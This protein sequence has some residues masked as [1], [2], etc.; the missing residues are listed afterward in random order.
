MKKELLFSLIYFLT[1]ISIQAQQTVGLFSN[2]ADA[3]NGYT[4]FTP[5][6]STET[7]LIDNCGEQVHNWSS[8]YLPGLSCYL[9]ENGILLRTGR[10]QGMGTGSGIVQ[11]ID[12]D[13][14]V[15]WEHSVQTT[16]GREHHDV[17]YLPN[18]NILLIVWDERTQA[19]VSQAGSSTNNAS[20]NSEQIVEIQPDLV[21]GGA[22]VV[23]EWKAWDHLI[24]DADPAADNYGVVADNPSRVDINFLALNNPDWLHFNGV[25]YHPEF[26][27]V[28]ISNHN[29]SE[30]WVIDHSTTT[31]EAAGSTGGV[32]GK[33]GDLIY[34]W[35]NAQAYGQGTAADQKLFLQH[36]THWIPDAYTDGGK[37]LMFNNQ[38]GTPFGQNYSTVNII[39]PPV[40][41][42]GFYTYSGGAF[43]PTDFDWTY[44]AP[45][46][47]DFYANIISGVYRL[48]ND[49]T[50]ICEGVGGRFFEVDP[51]GNTVWEY[52]NPVNDA[53]PIAQNTTATNNNAFRC[54]RYAPDY[55]GLAGQT[56]TPQ[57]YIETGSTF[58]CELFDT[59]PPV[60][61]CPDSIIVTTDM[62]VDT[63][64]A[65]GIVVVANTT[66][67]SPAVVIYQAGD[68]VLLQDSFEVQ[69]GAD[70][71]ALIDSCV[72]MM[73]TT[74]IIDSCI[75]FNIG[76]DTVAL[77]D[78]VAIFANETS[79]AYCFEEIDNVRKCY[80]NNWPG[81][82][83]GPFGGVNTLAAQDFE[84]SM[85]LYPAMGPGITP[86]DE[87]SGTQGCAGGIIFG[88]SEIGINYSPF[89]RLYFANPDTGVENTAWHIEADF[90]LN[91]DLNGGHV[92][93]VSRYHYHNIPLDYF[94]NDL[95]IDGTTHSPVLGYAAD[96]FPI[97]Y[98]YLYTDAI[99]INS[100]ITVFQSS[101]ALIS[102]TRPGDGITAPDGAYDGLYVEDYEYIDAQSELDECGGRFGITPD[103][104]NGTYYYVLTDNWPYIPRCL[105][106]ESVDNSFR[107]GPN[108]PASTAAN[109]CST[110]A[111][112]IGEFTKFN[113]NVY[114]Y[115]TYENVEINLGDHYAAHKVKSIKI[116]SAAGSVVYS[117]D[118]YE[119]VLNVPNMKKGKY[120]LQV[121]FDQKQITKKLF[122][123]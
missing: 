64:I 90:F 46:P 72:V 93:N 101:H 83:Y 19:E 17:E 111:P 69:L 50:L 92:N 118:E 121:D 109:D 5:Q 116:Y 79:S 24:Q 63:T 74:V 110:M 12:W 95:N 61:E 29:F 36:H 27:Q 80:T 103:Y 60:D 82:A 66:V 14:N 38:A 100:G 48:E 115:H 28:I 43:G 23:W 104:P 18:G 57:G 81:H 70:F 30:M 34:R 105:K 37:I 16:H 58:T 77:C 68:N 40:D 75:V 2:T 88:V 8:T 89:A 11:M 10:I 35:G 49:N 25:D 52:I 1:I 13:S 56:L 73:D 112:R 33:G 99:D 9:L 91:M 15:I 94:M 26:D 42:N 3:F 122:I 97:Y 55:P 96:G 120:F 108:C 119:K 41:A 85:C 117:S 62:G 22:T 113:E 21:N 6:N 71:T 4:L 87:T 84:Y 45:N 76:C 106:G 107:I 31:A 54:V 39:D 32:H 65:A 47:T 98:K 114:P 59:T 123:H 51:S 102:G 86:I 78:P 20:I 7:Y 53:G 67:L 44:Q